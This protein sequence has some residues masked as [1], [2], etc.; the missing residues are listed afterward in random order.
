MEYFKNCMTK[1]QLEAEHKRLVIQLHPDRNADNPN[2]TAKFQE[3]QA[4]YE[5]RLAELNGDY[6]KARK[7]RERRE[8]EERERRERERKEQARR[9]VEQVIEQARLNRQKSHREWK[10]GDY[11][12]ARMVNDTN[13]TM[14]WG[15]MT[16][17]DLLWVVA[18]HGVKD[19]CIVMIETIVEETADSSILGCG[20]ALHKGMPEGVWG[21][22]EVLQSADP[23][24]GIRKGKRVAKVVMYRSPNYCLF[25]NPMGDP[26]ISD[27][28]M[29]ISYEQM[30]SM[31]LGEIRARLVEMEQEKARIEAEKKARLIAEQTPLIAEWEPKLIG[32]SNGLSHD[33]RLTV[34][35]SNFKAMLKQK[36]QGTTFKVKKN[37]YDEVC[38][39]WE[40]G[41]TLAEVCDVMNLFDAWQVRGKELTP[42]MERYGKIPF[43]MGDV[44]RKMSTLTKARIL[45]QLGQV[46]ESF[47]NGSIDDSVELSD[48]DWMMLHLLVGINVNDADA[49]LCMS[50][51]SADG[52][53]MVRILS[54]VKFVF[55]YSSYCKPKAAKKKAA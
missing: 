1:E 46:S 55:T 4:Q 33:E 45:Q 36:F 9:R 20:Y 22:Y 43:S 25:A 47:R 17:E 35:I 34:A 40:D 53:R 8:R 32:M 16:C 54:A 5:E 37:R 26:F 7:G 30:F 42:W 48:I 39:S 50:N 18:Q 28:F 2:A 44:D 51:M 14:N 41:P 3:M 27:Y 21:G 24:N 23:A 19:E 29:P 15:A 52:K 12:Y 6:S 49:K 31:R 11:V 38:I 10:T 13:K